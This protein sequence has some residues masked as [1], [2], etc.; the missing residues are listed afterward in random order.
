MIQTHWGKMLLQYFMNVTKILWTLPQNIIGFIGY[1]IFR[2]G[3]KYKYNDAFIIE[4]PNKYGSVSLGN[5]IFVS[6]ATDEE[7]IKHEYGHTLQSKKLGWL[8]LFIIGMPS[9]IWAS[10]F[11][12][13][14]KKH[15]ISYYAFYT[16][17]W[18]NKLGGVQN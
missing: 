15:N 13:Y 5:F 10:C 12:G 14:R 16:E 9:I 2:K 11:E 8:Y 4:V 7:T 1:M 17:R 6:N 3:Y 18:A